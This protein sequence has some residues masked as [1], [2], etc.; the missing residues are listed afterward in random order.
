MKYTYLQW[1]FLFAWAPTIVIWLFYWRILITYLR[2]FL[3]CI[4]GSIVFATP[5]DYWATHHW[6]WHFTTDRT[7]GINF[8]GIPLEEYV[9]FASFTV[10]YTSLA[11][12]LRKQFK[13]SKT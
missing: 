6:L 2:V 5:W 8:L 1:F 4:I 3:L 9:F 7:I 11:L 10:L 12:I 13:I